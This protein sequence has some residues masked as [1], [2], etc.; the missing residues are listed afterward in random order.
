M[1]AEEEK[2]IR[3]RYA[4]ADWHVRNDFMALFA[5]LDEARAVLKAV[6]RVDEAW[7]AHQ[8]DRVKMA[9]AERDRMRE[10]LESIVDS[11]ESELCA[12]GQIARKA[13]GR[14]T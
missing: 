2:A 4:A 9:E 6:N 11:P 14:T 13:L 1:T 7:M 5:A 12:E 3:E 10:A 8:L